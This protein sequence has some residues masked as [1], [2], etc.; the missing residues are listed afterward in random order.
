MGEGEVSD[1]LGVVRNDPPTEP[2]P[3]RVARDPSHTPASGSTAAHTRLRGVIVAG[4]LGD[5]AV[6]R[7]ALEDPD[8]AVR[9][10]A[11]GALARAGALLVAD[12]TSALEDPSP[13]VRRRAC[14]E[15]AGVGGRG[16]R[17]TLPGALA[18]A[19]RDG[20]P[21]VVEA[22]CWAIGERRPAGSVGGLLEVASGHPDARCRE[23]AV[24]ALGALGD[25]AGLPGVLGAL[26]DKVTVRRRAAVALA[27]F[28]GPDVDE[29]LQRCLADHDWQVRQAAEVLLE[30]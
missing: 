26:D 29:A 7:G 28:D 27:A 2:G 24:G 16:S 22:A 3:Q 14:Q 12:V 18:G 19:L 25:P 13:L 11:V 9:A 6:A 23:A 17:A 20:D 15:A 21:L 8:P 30:Q 1:I 5:A 4:H 10:A